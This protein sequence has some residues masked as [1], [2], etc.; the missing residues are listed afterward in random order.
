ML[1]AKAA[2]FGFVVD[3]NCGINDQFS[4]RYNDQSKLSL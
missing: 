2:S 1:R 4:S 3:Q